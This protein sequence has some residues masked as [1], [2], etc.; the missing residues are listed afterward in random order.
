MPRGRR[1]TNN[2]LFCWRIGAIRSVCTIMVDRDGRP[3]R[4][5]RVAAIDKRWNELG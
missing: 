2:L 4:K 3:S 1:R 5:D